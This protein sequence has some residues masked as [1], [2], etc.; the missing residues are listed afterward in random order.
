MRKIGYAMALVL[1]VSLSG[2]GGGSGGGGGSN[3]P[4]GLISITR[5]NAQAVTGESVSTAATTD[6]GSE[7]GDGGPRTGV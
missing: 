4:A 6:Q 1:S 7:L 2:C 3:Q 5:S